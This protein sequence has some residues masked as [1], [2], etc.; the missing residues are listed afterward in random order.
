MPYTP[1]MRLVVVSLALLLA[2]PA[3]AEDKKPEEKKAAAKKKTAAKSDK[4][5]FQKAESSTGKFLHDNKI[6]TKSESRSRA[7]PK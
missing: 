5:V 6:W 2:L 1:A 3:V 4:N 7:D